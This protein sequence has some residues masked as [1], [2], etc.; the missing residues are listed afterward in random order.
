[1]RLT[2]NGARCVI[3]LTAFEYASD[4]LSY[5]SNP[6]CY[7][8]SSIHWSILEWVIFV[9]SLFATAPAIQIFV[10]KDIK[11]R[12]SISD[13]LD[14]AKRKMDFKAVE[15]YQRHLKEAEVHVNNKI[16]VIFIAFVLSMVALSIF[17]L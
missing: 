2:R 12:D 7:S 10:G 3:N 8:P 5:H 9:V 14:E 16:N 1:M 17:I 13:K 6:L 11:E 4:F 15:M